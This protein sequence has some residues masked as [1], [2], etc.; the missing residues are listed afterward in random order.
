[1]KPR[2][3]QLWLSL[4]ALALGGF[5]LHF[6]IH[7]PTKMLT[8]FWPSLFCFLDVFLVS[9]L[10]LWRKTAVWGLM[11]NS[12]FAFLGIIMMADLSVVLTMAGKIQ[13][14][15]WDSP[16]TWLVMTLFPDIMVTIA[17]FLVGLAL[18]KEVIL[19]VE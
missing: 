11:L 1:M 3:T 19:D 16:F 12:F 2:R 13:T 18:Y 9:G 6:R 17:D 10:F 7:P 14:S 15:P 8:N 4:V 5:F